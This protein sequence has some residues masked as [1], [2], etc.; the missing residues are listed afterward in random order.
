MEYLLLVIAR[1]RIEVPPDI[2]RWCLDT[3]T[4]MLRSW[5]QLVG[6]SDVTDEE[7]WMMLWRDGKLEKSADKVPAGSK[8]IGRA[9]HRRSSWPGMSRHT[10]HDRTSHRGG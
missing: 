9:T 8:A 1:A 3:A 6:R 2:M 10:W 5:T 4:P 7:A